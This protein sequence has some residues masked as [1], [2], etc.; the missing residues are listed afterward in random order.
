MN[1]INRFNPSRLKSARLY[2]GFTIT[3][4]SNLTSV[5]KQ[6]ISQFEH[7]KSQPSLETLFELMRVLNFPRDYFFWK[8]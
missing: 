7:G 6:A 2:E 1:K 8:R 4:L 3:D 5:S